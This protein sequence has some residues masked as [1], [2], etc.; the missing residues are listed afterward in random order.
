MLEDRLHSDGLLHS[1]LGTVTKELWGL[2]LDQEGIERLKT[3]GYQNLCYGSAEDPP[4]TVP[5]AYFDTVIAGEVIEHIRNVGRFLDSTA[6]LLAPGGSLVITTPNALRFYNVVP[7]L[8]RKELIHPD[9]VA[10]YSPHTLRRAVELSPFSV[11]SILMYD[12]PPWTDPARSKGPLGHL[13][14]R[15]FNLAIYPA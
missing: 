4:A 7:A 14:R 3:H 1:R 11:E 9:H 10:W 2:D 15:A 8:L 12:L 5:R 13:L 6:E